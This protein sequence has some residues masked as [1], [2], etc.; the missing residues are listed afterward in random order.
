MHAYVINLVRSRE[1]RRHIVAELRRCGVEFELIPAVDGRT[2][3]MKDRRIVHESVRGSHWYRPG[4]VPGCALS[5]V[6][7]YRKIVADGWDTA[8][9]LEDDVRLPEGLDALCESL[10]AE[11]TGAEAVLLNYDS[12][13]TCKMT[14]D[15][16][17]RLR[18]GQ[19]LALPLDPAQLL[20]TGA[21][22][23]TREAC[24]RMGGG[25]LPIRAKAD[26]WGY[27]QREGLL[28]RVRCVVPQAVVKSPRF[29]STVQ[30]GVKAVMGRTPVVRTAIAYRRE[31]L[32]RQ[33]ARTEFAD[34]PSAE[35]PSRLA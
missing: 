27:F 24:Q 29:G 9:V 22:V 4:V 25:L 15:G 5:H 8:L 3:D 31:R 20:S 13:E 7:V 18:R 19:V 26:D 28:D 33:Y 34:M 14:G 10:A 32:W 6:H 11:M 17:V 21:Y 30:G 2:V 23:I 16:L 1:R 35:Q 12:V